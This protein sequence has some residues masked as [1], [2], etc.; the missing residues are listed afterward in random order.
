MYNQELKNIIVQIY[1]E[2]KKR[3]GVQKIQYVLLRDYGIKISKGKVARLLKTM[4]LPKMSTL[5]PKYTSYINTI[6][7]KNILDQQFNQVSPNAVWV[8]DFTYLKAGS[9][10]VYLCV[11]L[12]L[13]SRKVITWN[14][15]SNIDADLLLKTFNKAYALRGEPKALMFHSDRGS[16]FTSFAFRKRLEE[17]NVLQSFSKKGH[18]YD[19][20]CM[21]CFF[22]YLKLEETNRH[23][24][25]S[26]EELNLA[27][28]E[29]IEGFYNSKRPH[30]SLNNLTPNEKEALYFS[31]QL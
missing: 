26:I 30:T 4:K 12:D 1:A 14:T 6:D 16:Q 2:A 25:H 11:I 29:Y 5:K 13:F 17:L 9:K 31:N 22:K 3:F 23:T 27:L 10:T 19:N 18:P 21:E 15:S 24:Y 28:F 20:A 7:C 8:S